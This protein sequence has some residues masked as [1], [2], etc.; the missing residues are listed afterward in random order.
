[1]KQHFLLVDA[2]K[3]RLRLMTN[4][5][6]ENFTG[7]KCTWAEGAAHA[8]KMLAFLQPEMVLCA[9][10]HWEDPELTSI[11]TIKFIPLVRYKDSTLPPEI[12][13]QVLHAD[14][15]SF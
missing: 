13:G 4:R 14:N 10:E 6:Q 5:L 3:E 8:V 7:C 9:I 15:G 2:D 1:M 12:F 11:T